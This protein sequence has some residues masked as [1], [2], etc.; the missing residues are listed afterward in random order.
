MYMPFYCRTR[1]SQ[2]LRVR[3]LYARAGEQPAALTSELKLN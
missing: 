3:S 1:R 2:R